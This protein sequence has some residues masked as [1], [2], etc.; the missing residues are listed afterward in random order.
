MFLRELTC[1]GHTRR[2]SIS[3]RS[4][5]GWVVR[6]EQD[7][8]ILKKVCYKDWHRVERAL[9]MFNLLAD[10]LEMRGWRLARS[11]VT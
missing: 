1:A 9:R 10:D 11:S 7:E 3:E 8:Q 4:E 5:T 6:D 2:F